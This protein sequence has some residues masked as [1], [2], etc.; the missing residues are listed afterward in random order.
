MAHN[1]PR[2]PLRVTPTIPGE[3]EFLEGLL[4]TECGRPGWPPPSWNSHWTYDARL[5]AWS[6]ARL[7]SIAQRIPSS[8][9]Y[10]T[11]SCTHASARVASRV[12]RWAF[13]CRRRSSCQAKQATAANDDASSAAANDDATASAHD[14][15]AA[16]AHDDDAAACPVWW[17]DRRP[18]D[19][20]AAADEAAANDDGGTADDASAA[21]A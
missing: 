14:D 21:A 5:L 18:N 7:R 15:D 9:V 11:M 10:S 8:A 20:E 17:S 1:L 19:D 3:C 6:C 13:T 4:E 16:S 12:V 2:G